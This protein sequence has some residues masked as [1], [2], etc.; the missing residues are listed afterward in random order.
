MA[1]IEERAVP[2]MFSSAYEIETLRELTACL[3]PLGYSVSQQTRLID[4]LEAVAARPAETLVLGPTAMDALL[5]AIRAQKGQLGPRHP[6]LRNGDWSWAMTSHLDFVVLTGLDDPVPNH[7]M[8]AVEFDGDHH[9]ADPL[10]VRRDERKNR[11]C[12]AA[13]LPLLRIDRR[14]LDVADELPLVRWIAELW[15]EYRMTMPTLMEERDARFAEL[16]DAEQ[17]DPLVMLDHPELDVEFTFALEHPFP[18]SSR[19]SRALLREHQCAYQ[20]LAW[21]FAQDEDRQVAKDRVWVLS[22]RRPPTLKLPVEGFRERWAAE[23]CLC[24]RSSG[25]EGFIDVMYEVDVA[26]SV[27]ITN[28]SA[29]PPIEWLNNPPVLPA[30]PFASAPTLVAKAMC[31]FTMLREAALLLSRSVSAD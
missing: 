19:V 16:S 17:A 13:G 30:G 24:H 9:L 8:F 29:V 5:P 10:Q 23:G 3:A 15:H 21:R 20:E 7:P 12:L 18:P 1:L 14:H 4:V 31:E 22:W 28:P 6:W 26:Y 25:R 27:G 2:E 11:L